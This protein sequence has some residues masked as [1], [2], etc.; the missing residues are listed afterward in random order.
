MGRASEHAMKLLS[1]GWGFRTTGAWLRVRV[2]GR[3]RL[4][5]SNIG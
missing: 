4:R 2:V 5:L 1:E 3:S